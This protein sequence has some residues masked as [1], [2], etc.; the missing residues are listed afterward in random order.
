MTAAS[1]PFLLPLS[2]IIDKPAQPENLTPTDAP[3]SYDTIQADA[4][5]SGWRSEKRPEPILPPSSP[6]ASPKSI[7]ASPSSASYKG[8]TRASSWF[9]FTAQRPPR[10]IHTTI[11][12][13]VRDLVKEQSSTSPAVAAAS[14]LESCADACAGYDLSLSSL[15]QEPSI[16]GHTPLYWAILKRPPDAEG[17]VPDLLTSLISYSTPLLPSTIADVRHACLLTSDQAL[18]QRLRVTPEFAPMSGT[19]EMLL[20][21]RIPM[22]EVVVRNAPGD[23]GAFSV[24]IEV[25]HFQKR[26]LV[27]K[28]IEVEFIAR[29]RMWRLEFSI[30]SPSTTSSSRSPR[31]PRTGSWCLS[32]SILEH[33]PPTYVDSRL[34]I[35]EP[36]LPS[37]SYPQPASSPP[38]PHPHP[39]SLMDR[40]RTVPPPPTPKSPISIRLSSPS[41]LVAPAPSPTRR[42]RRIQGRGRDKDAVEKI[43]V[44]LEDSA[45]GASLQYAGTRYIAP[46]GVLRARLE[47]RLGRRGEAEGECVVC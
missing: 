16:E 24:D 9:P 44:A 11:L 41:Q 32:L 35:P 17:S 31:G 21:A 39:Q 38:D 14:I 36:V 46:D 18:F 8:K 47:A 25:V 5:T 20:G 23:E 3:P 34:L 15:L 27:S 30:A 6:T 13:L 28:K 22:D 2:M 43:E 12:G 10:E 37:S 33:S 29:A 7:A 4:T 1:Q 26:M 40:L 19:D 45:M 42:E